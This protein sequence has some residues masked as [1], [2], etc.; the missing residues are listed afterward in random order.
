M[1]FFQSFI[2]FDYEKK[3]HL[4][5]LSKLWLVCYYYY[6]DH[7]SIEPYGGSNKKNKQK[8]FTRITLYTTSKKSN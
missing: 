3:T 5:E 1:D 7:R 2:D 4:C 8:V 6:Y